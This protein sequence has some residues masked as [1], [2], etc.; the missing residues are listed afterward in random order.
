[1]SLIIGAGTNLGSREQNLKT[2]TEYLKIHFRHIASSR[3]YHSSPVDN[4]NQPDF[5]NQ[6]HEFVCPD[7]HP[8]N[9]MEI[10][11]SIE[12]RMGRTRLEPKGPRIID[13]DLLF[14]DIQTLKTDLV[15]IPHPRLFQRSFVVY[16]L[17][18]LPYSAVLK[19]HF[20]FPEHFEIEAYAVN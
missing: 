8:N 4:T 5:L 12:A 7:I 9:V 19:K 15:E 16:P 13:L 11:L 18:E 14:W 6:V 10:L 17:R 2:A 20:K 3:I 1:M